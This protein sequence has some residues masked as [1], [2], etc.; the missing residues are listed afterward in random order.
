MKNLIISSVLAAT[1]STAAS[2]EAVT[3][4]LDPSHSQI[5][6]KYDHLGFS[7]TTGMFS[8]F[9]GTIELDADN[10]AASAVNVNFP[11][12]SLITGWPAR[13]EHFLGEDFFGSEANPAVTFTSTSVEVTGENTG[14]ITGDLTL[15][16]ITKPVVLDAT[17]NQLGEHPLANLPLAGFDATATLLRTDFDMGAFAPFVSDEI[18]I[19]ISIEALV[20]AE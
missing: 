11:A 6:F 7:T 12:E 2:A 8:G 13:E 16:G 4:V 19:A 10:P 5:V 9:E 3:Y 20:P 17:M 18:E 15:N 1:L 14:L